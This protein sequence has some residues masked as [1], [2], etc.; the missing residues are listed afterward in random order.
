[1]LSIIQLMEDLQKKEKGE[2]PVFDVFNCQ[3]FF[4]NAS[5]FVHFF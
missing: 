1:M 5:C 2:W 4:F 3:M